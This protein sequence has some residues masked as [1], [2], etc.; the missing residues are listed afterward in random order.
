MIHELS[1][2]TLME[3]VGLH[4]KSGFIKSIY[5]LIHLMSNRI[6]FEICLLHPFGQ[7]R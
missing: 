1:H 3:Y 2:A 6:I 4:V 7:V 5:Y